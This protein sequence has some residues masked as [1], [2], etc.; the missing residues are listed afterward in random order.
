MKGPCYANE[1]H[2]RSLGAVGTVHPPVRVDVLKAD[3]YPVEE[4]VMQ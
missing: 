4:G 3:G 1:A 2:S